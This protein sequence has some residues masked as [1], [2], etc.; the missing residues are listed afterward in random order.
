M[1]N[2]EKWSDF[3]RIGTVSKAHKQHGKWDESYAQF[4]CPYGCGEHIE[5][6]EGNVKSKKATKC[7][8]HLMVCTGTSS[9]GRKAVDDPRVCNE[10]N[11]AAQCTTHMQ[12]A[13]RGR[14]GEMT[15]AVDT[16]L[17][18]RDEITTLQ[19][20]KDTLASRNDGLQSRVQDLESQMEEMRV[21]DRQRDERERQR[22]AEMRELRSEMQQLRPL[23][24]LVQRITNEL[25]LAASVPPA[26]SIEAYV[27]KIDG[28]RKAAALATA[29][30]AGKRMAKLE[31]EMEALRQENQKL[32]PDARNGQLYGP[33]WRLAN[34]LFQEPKESVAF[35]RKA[36]LFAHPDKQ[37]GHNTAAQALQQILN[38][39]VDELRK[40]T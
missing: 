39:L 1:P 10:R 2:R 36:M 11:A 34:P 29:A 33:Y 37:P 21:R 4:Q 30:P 38:Y 24:P 26:A 6:P 22:D 9:D 13:K 15:A 25:G 28:L 40:E 14:V 17:A 5:L 16:T 7:H 20:S 27:D 31:R 19:T 12:A 8:D 32:L 35:L 18:L 3:T 23:V